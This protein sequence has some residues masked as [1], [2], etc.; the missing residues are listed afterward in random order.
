MVE[1][2]IPQENTTI[3]NIYATN[4]RA[5]KYR[6]QKLTELKDEID[7]SAIVVGDFSILFE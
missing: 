6:K 7:N 2:S 1:R 4:G 3:T 5:L